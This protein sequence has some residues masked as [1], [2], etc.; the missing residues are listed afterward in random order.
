MKSLRVFTLKPHDAAPYWAGKGP[1]LHVDL[2]P[3][4]RSAICSINDISWRVI[5]RGGEFTSTSYW[6]RLAMA[7]GFYHQTTRSEY[8]R[9]GGAYTY[10][11]SDRFSHI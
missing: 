4:E 3:A 11:N 9:L 5:Y 7:G 2:P 8:D 6:Q 1:T 10:V